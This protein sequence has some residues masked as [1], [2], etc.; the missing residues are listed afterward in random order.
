M[1][2]CQNDC[3]KYVRDVLLFKLRVETLVETCCSASAE[4]T[5]T[6]SSV[7]ST[8]NKAADRTLA[9]VTT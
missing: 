9:H 2:R 1:F 7:L 3:K 5:E 8:V 6:L 4:L